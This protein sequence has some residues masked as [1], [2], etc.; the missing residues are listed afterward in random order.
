MDPGTHYEN[1]IIQALNKHSGNSDIV[2]AGLFSLKCLT[3]N[4]F[5]KIMKRREVKF[6]LEAFKQ[7][8]NHKT[9]AEAYH[10]LGK[11]IFS[12]TILLPRFLK[13]EEPQSEEEQDASGVSTPLEIPFGPPKK[14]R[15]KM[16][17]MAKLMKAQMQLKMKI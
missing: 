3:N 12:N 15:I 5:D 10:E 8:Y 2:R 1:L 13:Q 6:D 9:D 7:G 17:D 16:E 14:S 4:D 11:D